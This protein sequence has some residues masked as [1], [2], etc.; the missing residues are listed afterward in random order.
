MVRGFF[1]LVLAYCLSQFYR[2][3]LSVFAPAL[4]ADIGLGPEDTSTALGLWFLVFAAMQIP[5]GWL[6]DHRSP[7]KTASFLLFVGGAGG[8]MVF[9]A[10][11]G[12]TTISLAMAL[13]GFGCSPVLMSSYYI[14]ARKAPAAKFGTMAGLVVG[15]GSLGNLF[16]SA[17]LSWAM[18]MIGWRASMMCLALVTAC[19]ALC[20]YR[21]V[22]DP[23]PLAHDPSG[24]KMGLMDLLKRPEIYPILAIALVIYAPNAGLRGSWIGGYLFDVYGLDAAEI[25]WATV[26]VAVAMIAGSLSFGP[27]DRLWRC[28]TIILSSSVVTLLLLIVLWWTAGE[29]SLWM[30]VA[31]FIAIGFV[32]SNYPQVMNHGRSMLPPQLVGRGVTLINLFS[33]GGAGLFQIITARVYETTLDGV[34]AQVAGAVVVPYQAVFMCFIMALAFGCVI[35]IFSKNKVEVG[36]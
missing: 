15:I 5:V 11:Q 22:E 19:I 8:A 17:P 35:Y 4:H 28:K 3:C 18:S 27:M 31:L 20:V 23:E 36:A 1:W 30:T 14:I 26:F 16:A 6:L 34:D 32:S 25:G 12:P 13:I 7:R 33:I 2:A 24:P 21:F 10:A 9:A 29:I